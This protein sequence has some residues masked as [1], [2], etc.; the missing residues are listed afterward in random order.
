MTNNIF[1]TYEARDYLQRVAASELRYFGRITLEHEIILKKRIFGTCKESKKQKNL[2]KSRFPEIK[3]CDSSRVHLSTTKDNS[4]FIHANYVNGFDY[5]KKFI[6]TQEPM[7][8]TL[9]DF[10]NMV[11]QE[12]TR[13]IV[14]L[15]DLDTIPVSSTTDDSR[16]IGFKLAANNIVVHQNFIIT[17]MNVYNKS[18][19][20]SRLVQHLK[21]LNWPKGG[22]PD[23]TRFLHFLTLVNRKQQHFFNEA[24]ANLQL[25]PG[26][27]I[28]YSSTGTGRAASFCAIDFCIYRIVQTEFVSVPS[29][30]MQIRQ[31][32]HSSI[33]SL[34]QYFFINNAV[35]LFL[36]I[37]QTN[38]RLYHE[39]KS[40]FS[41]KYDH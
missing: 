5:F 31:Q 11:W 26:P 30:T 8:S 40:H 37:I 21:F 23:V 39:L 18:T 13:V 20:Q 19:R 27:I 4:D 10:W 41:I 1:E 2:K 17:I 7:D 35:V 15:N 33:E 22:I 29:V 32:R 28:V 34:D 16:L 9:E 12:K 24:L 25:P 36:T 3:C 14:M 6:V 38:H